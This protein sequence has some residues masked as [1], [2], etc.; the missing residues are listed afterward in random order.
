MPDSAW[1]AGSFPICITHQSL[2]FIMTGVR[3]EAKILNSQL[4]L[5][6]FVTRRS[7]IDHPYCFGGELHGNF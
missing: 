3:E 5:W 1:D 4:M 2:F 6:L 7:G